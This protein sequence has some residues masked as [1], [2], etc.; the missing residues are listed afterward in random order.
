VLLQHP[1]IRDAA[2]I[3]ASHPTWGEVGV[4]F[5]VTDGTKVPTSAELTDFLAARLAK[6]KIPRQFISV[7]DLP[8]T[9]YGKVVKGQLRELFQDVLGGVTK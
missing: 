1:Q 9:A 6:Y 5:L 3:G 7:K 2:V 4:A 8:R